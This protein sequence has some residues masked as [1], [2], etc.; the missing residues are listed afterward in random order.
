MQQAGL[1]FVKGFLKTP[2][3]TC[4]CGAKYYG[5]PDVCPDCYGQPS[6]VKQPQIVANSTS[7]K[8]YLLANEY[9]GKFFVKYDSTKLD[10]FIKD[11]EETYPHK[12]LLWE[13]R[14]MNLW[15][16]TNQ[17]KSRYDRFIVNWMGK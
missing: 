11:L 10:G 14:K 16:K 15:L 1:S 3:K 4:K 13:L 6:V 7:V 8:G 2:E 12:D 17:P 5:H 9:F